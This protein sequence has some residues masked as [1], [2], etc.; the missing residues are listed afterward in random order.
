[1]SGSNGGFAVIMLPGGGFSSEYFADGREKT[2]NYLIA[3]LTLSIRQWSKFTK[4]RQENLR[5]R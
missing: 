5:K 4:K 3:R 1:M 2:H